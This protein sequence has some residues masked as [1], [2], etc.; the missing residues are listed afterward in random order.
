MMQVICEE[1]TVSVVQGLA[2]DFGFSWL[3]DTFGRAR[4]SNGNQ[5]AVAVAIG[6]GLREEVGPGLTKGDKFLLG[7]APGAHV[8]SLVGT[9]N[10]AVGSAVFFQKELAADIL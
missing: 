3:V 4:W 1:R 7:G 10:C 6:S 5:I 9:G 2:E 8:R